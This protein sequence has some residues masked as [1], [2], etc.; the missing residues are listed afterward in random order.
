MRKMGWLTKAL[1]L[2]LG[3]L[4]AALLGC[5]GPTEQTPY[6]EEPVVECLLVAGQGIDEFKFTRT[7]PVGSDYDSAAAAISG[8]R[9]VISSTRGDS[10]ILRPVPGKPGVYASPNYIVSAKATYF[11][12]TEFK[13]V[14]ITAETTCPDTFKLYPLEKEI[15]T[16]LKDRVEV[17]W[18]QSE[19]AAAFYISVTNLEDSL[20]AIERPFSEQNPY[21]DRRAR[22]YWTLGLQTELYPWLHNF[23]GLHVL[24]VYAIDRNFFRYLQT[25]FQNP[26]E[27]TEPESSVRNAIGYFGSATT[28]VAS[29]TL[30]E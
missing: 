6:V 13:G 3:L 24:R 16:Y 5:S 17:H 11:L 7:L 28:Q 10:T 30:V 26:R 8:A 20:V 1:S 2:W 27:L 15:V 14:P 29:Y 19:G 9:I 18:T 21:S 12:R 25:S 22:F 4:A 23:Y